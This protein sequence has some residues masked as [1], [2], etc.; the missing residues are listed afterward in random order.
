M[1]KDRDF[2]KGIRRFAFYCCE[3]EGSMGLKQDLQTA[4]ISTDVSC[5]Y[6]SDIYGGWCKNNNR[7]CMYKITFPMCLEDD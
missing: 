1:N 2:V 5:K 7:R 3:I 6:Y 4:E